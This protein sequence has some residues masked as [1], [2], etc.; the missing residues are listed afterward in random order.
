MNL[1]WAKVASGV[2]RMIQP[3]QPPLSTPLHWFNCISTDCGGNKDFQHR[4]LISFFILNKIPLHPDFN[5]KMHF[6]N[7]CRSKR[8][9]QDKNSCVPL[10][11]RK[12]QDN[13]YV[14]WLV[15]ECC[16][17]KNKRRW[18]NYHYSEDTDFSINATGTSR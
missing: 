13:P 4:F 12:Y 1:F 6:L 10:E 5:S 7:L 11:N 15:I 18:L 8:G 17:L 3:S 14:L 16:L 9:Q 2:W